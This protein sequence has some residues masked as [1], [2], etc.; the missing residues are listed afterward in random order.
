M[1]LIKCP[2]TVEKLTIRETYEPDKKSIGKPVRIRPCSEDAE[3]KTMLGFYLGDL[4]FGS[5]MISFYHEVGE[6]VIYPYCN[7]AIFVP[8][9]GRVVWGCESW[10]GFVE[11][12]DDLHEITNESI[13]KIWYVQALKALAEK[14]DEKDVK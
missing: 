2:F 3:N 7:P 10:W 4:Q 11:S 8:E 14:K 6:L 9:L 5:P 13:S 1:S 12:E